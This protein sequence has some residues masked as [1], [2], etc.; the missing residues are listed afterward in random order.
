MVFLKTDTGE[1]R[2]LLV[3]SIVS[4]GRGNSNDIRPQNQSVSKQHAQITLSNIPG[5]GKVEAWLED[6]NSSY[7]T[8]AGETPLEIER[9]QGKIKLYFG[10]YM[11]FGHAPNYFQYLENIPAN[12]EVIRPE[13]IVSPSKDFQKKVHE[14]SQNQHQQQP[15][16]S[17]D[18]FSQPQSNVQPPQQVQA[19]SSFQQSPQPNFNKHQSSVSGFNNNGDNNID[20]SA[21][22]NSGRLDSSLNI[23]PPASFEA[24][25]R[26]SR[27]STGKRGHSSGYYDSNEEDDNPRNMQISVNYPTS[28]R[29]SPQHP[30]TIRIDGTGAEGGGYSDR[31]RSGG[32]AGN[33]YSTSPDDHSPG[34]N[35]SFDF[36]RAPDYSDR[37]HP[38]RSQSLLPENTS[39]NRV[40]WLDESYGVG[41][42]GTLDRVAFEESYG[43]EEL[44][45]PPRSQS[46]N[47]SGSIQVQH[48]SILSGNYNNVSTSYNSNNEVKSSSSAVGRQGKPKT[49]SENMR[50]LSTLSKRAIGQQSNRIGRSTASDE[51]GAMHS[52]YYQNQQN[53]RGSGGTQ[54]RGILKASKQADFQARVADS[55]VVMDAVVPSKAELVR[56]SWPDELLLPSSELIAGFVDLLLA[57]ETGTTEKEYALYKDIYIGKAKDKNA[58]VTLPV[59]QDGQLDSAGLSRAPILSFL[60]MNPVKCE[61]PIV[62]P[63]AVMSEAVAETIL[64]SD[65]T[66]TGL[67]GSTIRELNNLLRQ[68]LLGTQIDGSVLETSVDFDHALQGVI[69]SILKHASAQ[70][71]CAQQS[72]VIVA[73]ESAR[74]K[75]GLDIR[76]NV[77]L[78]IQQSIDSLARINSLM[79]GAYLK[80]ETCMLGPNHIYEMV[81]LAL[82]GILNKLDACNVSVWSISQRADE[83][84]TILQLCLNT[85]RSIHKWFYMYF[86]CFLI[87]TGD[88]RA[89]SEQISRL[90]EGVTVSGTG[91]AAQAEEGLGPHSAG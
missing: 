63:D 75:G 2:E 20:M 47:R 81:A 91:G 16:R 7:G 3:P 51:D 21:F 78:L 24:A 41:G 89:C 26:S 49:V 15:Q 14:F 46:Y 1:F 72:N 57:Q 35:M 13:I 85:S 37:A 22:S 74:A 83:V 65:S 59:D 86:D 10:F 50:E 29:H 4:I 6:L 80:E 34:R 17:H 70:L 67:I 53:L 76:T 71:L 19:F 28:N 40:N 87:I 30:V 54:P 32:A 55:G 25:N 43:K 23:A 66:A 33:R 11:R 82:S 88:D 68:C 12:A 45:S 61:L 90:S 56:R 9:V 64:D 84:R 48:K 38:G 8:Y 58:K 42:H 27:P 36:D 31:P 62:L 73:L 18:E 69:T 60:K 5:T 79:S 44:D 52:R 39:T 77:G